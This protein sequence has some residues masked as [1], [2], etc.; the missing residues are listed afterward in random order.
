MQTTP[1]LA[2][3]NNVRLH[4]AILD[5]LAK[6]LLCNGHG[7]VYAL[8]LIGLALWAHRNSLGKDVRPQGV[9]VALEPALG[10]RGR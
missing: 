8:L 4:D 7:S 1:T 3:E 10:A 2:E 9:S 5:Q 6:F